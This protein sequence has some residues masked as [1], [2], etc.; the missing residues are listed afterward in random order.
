MIK[1]LHHTVNDLGTHSLDISVNSHRAI[2][3]SATLNKTMVKV[4][5]SETANSIKKNDPHHK[6]E[7]VISISHSLRPI[8]VGMNEFIRNQSYFLQA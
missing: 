7:R 4:G 5:N 8:D 3:A 2:A 1:K 6:T